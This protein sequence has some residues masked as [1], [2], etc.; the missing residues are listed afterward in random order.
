MKGAAMN[1]DEENHPPMAR[2]LSSLTLGITLG[3]LGASLCG[4][5][6]HKPP[7]QMAIVNQALPKATPLP[8]AWSAGSDAANV[9]DDWVKSFKDDELGVVVREAIANN[10]DLRQSADQVEEARQTV[11]VV[12]SKLKPQ[13]G[14]TI[15]GATTRSS[16]AASSNQYQSNMEYGGISWEI[17][18]WGQVR[19]QRAA[20]QEN[21]E[22]VALDYAFA[23]QSLAAT[24]AKSWY[25]AIETRRLVAL[26]EQSVDIYTSLLDLAKVRRAAGKVAD[27][28]V[29]EASY[30]L[31]EA[32]SE[33]IVIQ[34]LYSESRRTLEVLLGRYPSA[35]L[36]VAEQ[37]APLP[38]PVAPGLPSSLLERR[39]D[40]VAAEHQVFSAFQTRQAAKLALLPRFSFDLEGGR[41]SDR[42]LSVLGLN[43]WLM[44]S[45]VGM[46]V[47]I[48]EGGSL[49][50]QIRIA[51]AQE[52][53]AVAHFGGVALK[54]FD[55]VEV[56]L[57]NERLLAERLPHMENAVLNHTEAVRVAELRYR[58]G[59]MDLL[60]VLQ[61]QEGQIQSQTDLIKLR[62][63]QLANRI[64]LHLALGGS[65]DGSA[66]G[67]TTVTKP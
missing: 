12:G 5:S 6:L 8:P 48:Y 31:N 11:I 24:T 33:L 22:A 40:I 50:A 30:Q 9:T 16:N 67:A 45:V 1:P 36:A 61:L 14:A 46:F 18:V 55:E 56:A 43:P 66:P 27:L 7:S 28:D 34:G 26:A 44:H 29:A 19:S 65:F 25:L 17:D 47:P 2:V 49:Q 60:S 38:P 63:T 3:T 53:Q 51:T 13:I 52:D 57:T 32:Q 37:Y 58:A 20:V 39:P 15:A 21:Y 42:L 23:R 4:C 54:A 10:L 59:S 64:N 41:L 62:N 35:E